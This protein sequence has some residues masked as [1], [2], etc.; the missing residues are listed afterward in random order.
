MKLTNIDATIKTSTKEG[1]FKLFNSKIMYVD[2]NSS[3][4]NDKIDII[5]GTNEISAQDIDSKNPI[6]ANIKTLKAQ[7]ESTTKAVK[8]TFSSIV[9]EN[10]AQLSPKE[11]TDMIGLTKSSSISIDLGT[12]SSNV[13]HITNIFEILFLLMKCIV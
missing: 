4:N 8:S 5:E 9:M 13:V 10:S 6:S 7:G 12:Y 2:K 1:N 11:D 3:Y